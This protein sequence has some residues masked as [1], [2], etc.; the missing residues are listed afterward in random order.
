MISLTTRIAFIY[1]ELNMADS[2]NITRICRIHSN[3]FTL[4]TEEVTVY[5]TISRETHYQSEKPEMSYYQHL[6][7]S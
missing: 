4:F 6:D 3:I 1:H 7:L 2:K 5:P